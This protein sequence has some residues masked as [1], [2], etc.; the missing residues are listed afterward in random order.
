MQATLLAVDWGSTNRRVFVL[1]ADGTILDT[2]QDDRGIL[3]M[4]GSSFP[5]EAAAMRARWGDLPMLCAGMVGS[6]RGWVDAGYVPAP[7]S[8]AAIAHAVHWVERGRTA[9]VPGVSRVSDGRADIMR[10]EE[11]Q[12]LGA[13]AAGLVNPD[14][15]L[16]QPGTHAK[17]ARLAGGELVDFTTAM[18]GEIFAQ[19][20]NGGLLADGLD[21]AVEP[22]ASFRNGVAAARGGDLLAK[23]FGA[24]ASL[25]LGKR[26]RADQASYVSGLLIGSDCSARLDS[27]FAG[28]PADG[29][30]VLASPALGAL[31]L[32]ALNELGCKAR[33]VDSHA[34]FL[35]GIT[36]IWS[37]LA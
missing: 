10:G 20:G 28:A 25:V 11:V 3:N 33:L 22:G 23:L 8:L 27:D 26:D 36:Q 16:C 34:A 19:L 14:S 5:A 9:I 13:A 7:A 17:W 35:A 18:T 1:A 4:G 15:W 2:A 21:G 37:L 12:L 31:Y 24:R 30:D 6:N 29:V 32:A